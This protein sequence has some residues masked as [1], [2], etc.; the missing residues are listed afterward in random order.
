MPIDP[1]VLGFSNPWYMHAM[2]TAQSFALSAECEIKL[3]SAPAFIATKLAAFQDRGR[4]D[5]MISH[6]LE[7]ILVVVDGRESL[8][9]E[10]HDADEDLRNW[11]AQQLGIL[12]NQP[13]FVDALPGLIDDPMREALVLQRLQ[14]IATVS[15]AE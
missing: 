11:V 9:S 15:I 12:L 5:W 14:R 4:S 3:I 1:T 13:S 7:D 2:K 8:V 10:L 6:D